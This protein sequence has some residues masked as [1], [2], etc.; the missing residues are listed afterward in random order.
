MDIVA[1]RTGSSYL[2]SPRKDLNVSPDSD[3]LFSIFV[4]ETKNPSNFSGSQL[5]DLVRTG[6]FRKTLFF[7]S[8][9]E[10]DAPAT[11][12]PFFGY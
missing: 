10:N 1:K 2:R 8:P 11:L 9:I 7:Q 6:N 3:S 5:R 12:V 4:S